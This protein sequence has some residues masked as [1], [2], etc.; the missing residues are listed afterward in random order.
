M[1]AIASTL[2]VSQSGLLVPQGIL[3]DTDILVFSD[4]NGAVLA[5]HGP[6]AA[7]DAT[8]LASQARLEAQRQQA[9]G[10]VVN[11][12]EKAGTPRVNYLFIA[13]PL[14]LGLSPNGMAILGDPSDPYGLESRLLFT[15]VA[16]SLA[17]L[18]IALLGGYWLAD[19]AMRPVHTITQA[20]RNIGET[21]V[22]TG[23]HAGQTV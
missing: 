12:T 23:I 14:R 10:N 15:L 2:T 17:T 4:S 9:P 8:R 7:A 11:W 20:A 5:S 18:I 16:G 6:I 21:L 22:F 3:Q 13:V 19:R 1:A